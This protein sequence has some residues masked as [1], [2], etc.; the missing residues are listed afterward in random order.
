MS[1][2]TCGQILVFQLWIF[3]WQVN[4]SMFSWHTLYLIEG[5]LGDNSI[6]KRYLNLLYIDC[7]KRWSVLRIWLWKVPQLLKKNAN[8]Y[9][10]IFIVLLR[11]RKSVTTWT[12][13]LA[14]YFTNIFSIWILLGL[15]LWILLWRIKFEFLN[16]SLHHRKENERPLRR[17]SCQLFSSFSS[18]TGVLGFI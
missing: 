4:M 16:K 13:W 5:R 7:Y 2:V 9:K 6:T 1:H 3:L 11:S 8:N 14:S 12:K 10:L 18:C 17:V 15:W